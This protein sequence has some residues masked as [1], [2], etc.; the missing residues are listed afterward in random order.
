MWDNEDQINQRVKK[1]SK[2]ADTT[3]ERK[4]RGRGHESK[5]REIVPGRIRT[6]KALCSK[7]LQDFKVNATSIGQQVLTSLGKN[8]Q[9]SFVFESKTHRAILLAWCFA[10]IN[11]DWG[12][13]CRQ[14]VNTFADFRRRWENES[15]RRMKSGSLKIGNSCNLYLGYT[16]PVSQPSSN[17]GGCWCDNNS[18]RQLARRMKYLASSWGNWRR[19]DDSELVVGSG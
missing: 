5:V 3:K 10:E 18:A 2:G 8:L 4:R 13:L 14:K 15:P 6:F 16:L 17:F 12:P 11:R 1:R 9:C 7:S 19:W